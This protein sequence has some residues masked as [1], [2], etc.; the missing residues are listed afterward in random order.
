MSHSAFFSPLEDDLE[1][2][3]K[4]KPFRGATQ[5]FWSSSSNHLN[6]HLSTVTSDSNPRP[7]K[8]VPQEQDVELFALKAQVFRLEAALQMSPEEIKKVISDLHKEKDVL[9]EV[10]ESQKKGLERTFPNVLIS[11]ALMAFFFFFFFF[12]INFIPEIQSLKEQ[13]TFEAKFR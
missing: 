8:P 11:L 12:L 2:D 9:T 7:Q 5:P 4:T 3:F 13:V 10:N 6:S 1:S